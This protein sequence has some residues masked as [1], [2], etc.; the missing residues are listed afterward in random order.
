MFFL[1]LISLKGK[2]NS[3]LEKLKK[4]IFKTRSHV[5]TCDFYFHHLREYFKIFVDRIKEKLNI[6]DQT[7][8]DDIFLSNKIENNYNLVVFN[9]R[10]YLYLEIIIIESHE[11]RF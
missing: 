11:K 5:F 9:L 4:N 3:C 10:N 1:K 2:E 8:K 7:L 6:Y